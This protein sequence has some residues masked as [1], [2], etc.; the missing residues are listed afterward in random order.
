MMNEKMDFFPPISRL[1]FEKREGGG[2]AHKDITKLIQITIFA[3]KYIQT[4]KEEEF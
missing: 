3:E 2:S 1:Y 4:V